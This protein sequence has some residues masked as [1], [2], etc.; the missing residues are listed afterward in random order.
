MA[1]QLIKTGITTGQ[2]IQ[3]GHVTQSVDALTGTSAYDIKISGSL[4]LTGSVSS[5]NG[6][7]GNLTGTSSWASNALISNTVRPSNT[8]SDFGYTVPYLSGTGSTATLY[9]SA[10][11]PTYNPTTETITSTNFE[12]T[13]SLATTASYAL[14]AEDVQET[15]TNN[16]MT[17]YFQGTIYSKFDNINAAP[18]TN[19]DL[20]SAGAGTF[21][22]TRTLDANFINQAANYDAK[23]LKFRIVGKFDAS[24]GTSFE[25]YVQL[26]T[27]ILN[28]TKI[29]PVTLN[30]NQDHPFEVLYDLVFQNNTIKACG[31]I[32]Y[33]D[34][35]G[36]LKRIP[37]ANLYTSNP[38]S[39]GMAGNIQ[40]IVSGSSNTVMTGS[41][42]YIEFMN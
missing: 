20:L 5:L 11:G 39:L 12:G 34:N 23:I 8:V 18:G 7:T 1:N 38:V 9:Y 26:G 29:G 42:A 25:S 21:T 35:Q 41:L 19:Y 40:F 3:P 32:S 27:D 16:Y 30:T 15:F 17:N 2:T 31:S 24:T 10:T 36:D 28:S 13:A 6:F 14:L 22:G 37:I 4:T 33:C